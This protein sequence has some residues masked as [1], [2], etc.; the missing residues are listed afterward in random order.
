[1]SGRSAALARAGLCA[2]AGALGLAAV[3]LHR[4][5]AVTLEIRRYAQDVAATGEGIARNTDVAHELA[6]LGGLASAVR[7]A[8]VGSPSAE[9][10]A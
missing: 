7:S 4:T 8:A 2:G 5:L 3:L 9:E 1:M 6:R 10:V